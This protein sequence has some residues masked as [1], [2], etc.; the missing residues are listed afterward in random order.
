MPLAWQ[1]FVAGASAS[2]RTRKRRKV[3]S[4]MRFRLLIEA[5]GNDETNVMEYGLPSERV[6]MG[7][8]T[9]SRCHGMGYGGR[10]REDE[11]SGGCAGRVG[12]R[13]NA[14]KCPILRPN[15]RGSG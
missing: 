7:T 5:A 4:R 9:R 1:R 15:A 6:G 10:E 3:L 14:L 13:Q 8:M 12:R 11:L 2:R